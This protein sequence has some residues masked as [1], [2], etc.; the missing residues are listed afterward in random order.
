MEVGTGCYYMVLRVFDMAVLMWPMLQL[1]PK[2]FTWG[3]PGQ[4]TWKF[5]T[6]QLDFKVQATHVVSPMAAWAA[7]QDAADAP[8]LEVLYYA[9]GEPQD[10][11]QFQSNRGFLHIPEAVLKELVE[12]LGLEV[13]AAAG[14][15]DA[16]DALVMPIIMAV[17]PET[18]QA[19][20]QDVLLQ[21]VRLG[22]P[23]QDADVVGS[24]VADDHMKG[25]MTES[26]EKDAKNFVE[27]QAEKKQRSR[28]RKASITSLVARRFP[29][30]QERGAR[31]NKMHK[32]KLKALNAGMEGL[33]KFKDSKWCATVQPTDGTV[34]ELL[35]P[36]IGR[37]FT[38]AVNG[39]YRLH[40]P[41]ERSKSVSWTLRGVAKAQEAA[42]RLLWGW[43]SKHSMEECPWADLLEQSG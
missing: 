25:V 33:S 10:L 14:D 42:V 39:S 22:G 8:Q 28:N 16:E 2:A 4:L 9:V 36:P 38:D 11:L 27:E 15:E 3:R 20:L 5:A 18:T 6:K 17:S 31:A 26:D 41:G 23:E 30:V 19:Q 7:Q 43:H 32:A 13:G 29:A 1:R 35:K 12:E 21:R 40:Y 34:M 37:I 24:F